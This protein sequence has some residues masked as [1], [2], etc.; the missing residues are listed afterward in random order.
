MRRSDRSERATDRKVMAMTVK[1]DDPVRRLMHGEVVCADMGASL[2]EL[3]ETMSE[4]EVGSVVVCELN[5]VVGIVTERDVVAALGDGADP[6][7][8]RASDIMSE[9]PICAEPDDSLQLTVER[10]IEWSVH[11]LPVVQSGKA[12][13]MVSTKDLFKAMAEEA[14]WTVGSGAV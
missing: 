2:R 1:A 14:G 11:H 4:E 8:L 9:G 10:M 3:A 5:Q 6:D 7:D 12:I 13:G